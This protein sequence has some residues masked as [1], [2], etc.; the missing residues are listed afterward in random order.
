VRATKSSRLRLLLRKGQ[1]DAACAERFGEET[2]KWQIA[3][4]LETNAA[5]LSLY[6]NGHQQPPAD[7]V[8]RVLATFPGTRFED[9]FEVDREQVPA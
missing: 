5:R 8:A 7:F 1:F 2:P 9:L 3:D 4:A 6:R